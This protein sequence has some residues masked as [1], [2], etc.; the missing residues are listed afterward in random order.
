MKKTQHLTEAKRCSSEFRNNKKCVS[1]HRV[2][3]V[4]FYLPHPNIAQ[5]VIAPRPR[6]S[7]PAPLSALEPKR[8]TDSAVSSYD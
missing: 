6:S 2:F 5:F 4:S 3:K 1:K 7:D 8:T